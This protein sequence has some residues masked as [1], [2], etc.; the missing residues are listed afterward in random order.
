MRKLHNILEELREERIKQRVSVLKGGKTGDDPAVRR[1]EEEAE[2]VIGAIE[3]PRV[4]EAM[5]LNIIDGLKA[6]QVG[7]CLGVSR[8]QA[9]RL[10]KA[11]WAVCEGE[12]T[13]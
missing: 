13:E 10:I 2:E 4:R 3:N 5:R 8:A 1:L 9:Y 12:V 6:P 7:W 11:G